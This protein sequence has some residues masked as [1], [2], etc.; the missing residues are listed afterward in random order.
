MW[1][2]GSL[3]MP[4]HM[5]CRFHVVLHGGEPL[6]AGATRLGWIAE[7]LRNRLAGVC[8]LDLRIH[9]ND[10]L[11][12][13]ALGLAPSDLI[14]IETDGSYEQ[15]GSL[16]AAYNVAPATGCTVFRHSVDG[17]GTT[18]HQGTSRWAQ[19]LC[20]ECRDCPVV[21]RCGGGLYAH[22]CRTG[23]GFANPSVY[24]PALRKLIKHINIGARGS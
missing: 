14:V 6:L 10:V 11:L 21:A 8:D 24:C 5:S 12:D 13:Q 23:N 16:K 17:S 2:T 7:R 15:A 4:G 1:Q 22:R 3:I 18:R 19:G 9:T 20:D